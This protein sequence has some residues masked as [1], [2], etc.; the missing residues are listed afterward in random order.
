MSA[1]RKLDYA[2][3]GG[4]IGGLCLGLAL[5]ERGVSVHI[6]EAAHHF[7]E[8]GAGVSF[9]PNAVQA[10]KICHPKAVDAFEK[11]CTRNQWPSKEKNWFDGFD[12]HVAG[13]DGKSGH[14]FKIETALGQNGVHRAHFLGELVKSFPAEQASFGKRVEKYTQNADGDFTLEFR[15]GTTATAHAIIGCDGIK[16]H[17]RSSMFGHEH[18]CA[19]PSYTH[20]YAYRALAPM[21]QAV[22]A[23]GEEKAKNACAYVR[24]SFACFLRLLDFA[25]KQQL[26]KD[27]H[28]LTFAINQGE[29]LNLVGFHTDPDEWK[30]AEHLT[31][32]AHRED[33]LR[34]FGNFGPDVQKLLKLAKPDLDVVSAD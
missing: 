5:V 1:S 7:G 23:V 15:D 19:R 11:V 30:D 32:P 28:L 18:P 14:E 8:I 16:S 4:G 21:D 10:M 27:H 9:T 2:I 12:G 22:A 6:Y 25:N 17:V 3:I 24:R 13:E 26:G 20:K 34:D 33:A 31:A 29:I